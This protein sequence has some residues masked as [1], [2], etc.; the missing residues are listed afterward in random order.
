MP[1]PLISLLIAFAG[2]LVIALLFFPNGGLLGYLQRTRQFSDRVQRE[3]ALKHLHKNERHGEPTSLESLAGDIQVSTTRAAHIL[4]DL[5]KQELVT[6]QGA[7]FML[8]PKGRDY[9]LRIVRAH[10][11]WESYL[12]EETGFDESEW[13][14]RAHQLEHASTPEEI[15]ALSAQLGNPVYD[16][17]GD[18]IPTATGDFHHHGGQPITSMT[19]DTPLR[20]VHLEDEP[21]AVYA[22]LVAEGLHPGMEVRLVEVSPQRVR[23][24]AGSEEHILAPIV[25][26]SLS[27]VPI[28][29]TSTGAE[30]DQQLAASEPLNN[31]KPG[32]EGRVIALG[33]RLRGSE[34]RRMMD[35][36]LLPGT[37]VRAEMVSPG[38]DPTAYR[39]RGAMIALRREQAQMIRIERLSNS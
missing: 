33:P 14:A 16:P 18:P 1:D 34:R 4:E 19:L 31:L 9:A 5:Q 35:L 2:L 6:M 20:I 26:S 28:P 21:S 30:K 15:A 22:Q 10:R 25:A 23:F 38:G 39:I 3:D 29:D 24:W 17:H 36:G 12:A 7:A 32:Q 11:L 13:H 8:T 27:V 37:I